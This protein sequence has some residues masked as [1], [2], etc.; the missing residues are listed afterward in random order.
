MKIK[1]TIIAAVIA[2]TVGADAELTEKQFAQVKNW[3]DARGY[4]YNGTSADFKVEYFDFVN[5]STDVHCIAPTSSDTADEAINALIASE[6]MFRLGA[7]AVTTVKAISS[8]PA[9]KTATPSASPQVEESDYPDFT[10]E[11]KAE[12]ESE[13]NETMAQKNAVKMAEEYLESGAFSRQG[14][15]EQLMHEGFSR[16]DAIYGADNVGYGE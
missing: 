4:S 1:T 9:V 10:D 2:A 3:A 16:K 11:A 15:I 7:L 8:E 12:M 14:L 13:A 6:V 5:R